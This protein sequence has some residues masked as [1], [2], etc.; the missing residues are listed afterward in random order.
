MKKSF[1][2]IFFLMCLNVI[3]FKLVAQHGTVKD[4]DGNVYHT[5]KIGKQVW[6]KENLKTTHFQDGS[7]ITDMQDKTIWSNTGQSHKP[8]Y[9]YYGI[10]DDSAT[11]GKNDAK[12]GK[13]NDNNGK[14]TSKIETEMTDTYGKLY[15]WFAASDPRN[16]CPAGWRVPS[17]ADYQA[18][19]NFL[20]GDSIAGAHMK[21]VTLW[22]PPNW[23][24]DN[25]SGFSA[26]PAG[27]RF[28]DGTFITVKD[29][30]IFWS[31]TGDKIGGAWNRDAR[32][33]NPTIGR[34]YYHQ[35]G[36]FSIRCI[37]Q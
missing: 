37:K 25:S 7:A 32:A 35:E 4:V 28:Y 30:T 3:G 5:V 17:D 36:G 8:G 33:E 31:S 26:L 2:N 9:C 18:L 29:R 15:N 12:Y 1:G 16:I 34:A 20:G 11:Y 27:C 13:E 10:N 19:I 22:D 24:A 23:G 6:L 21:A 14:I